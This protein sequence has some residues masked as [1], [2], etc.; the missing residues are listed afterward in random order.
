MKTKKAFTLIELLV[1]ISIIALLMAIM[2]PA[3][4]KA[5]EVAKRTI[6][7][8]NLKNIW[9]AANMYAC[10]WNGNV[11]LRHPLYGEQVDGNQVNLEKYQN[12]WA[13]RYYE[14]VGKADIF[15]CPAYRADESPF[16]YPSTFVP[17]DGESPV[18]ITYTMNEFIS[19]SAQVY[20]NTKEMR[21]KIDTIQKYSAKDSWMGIFISDG[22]FEVDNWGDR[23]SLG[24]TVNSE[25]SRGRT[26]YRHGKKAM[27]LATDGRIGFYSEKESLLLPMQ[28][29]REIKPSMLK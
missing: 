4:G 19:T 11:S 6:C 18:T 20:D 12:N 27:F 7:A 5:R 3:L 16:K 24:L 10:D 23:R 15:S 2:L 29:Y 21:Y 26:S 17:P 28:G 9:T 22:L 1:V 8:T 14:Y 13:G 25:G